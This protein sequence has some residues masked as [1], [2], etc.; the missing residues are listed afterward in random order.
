MATYTAR[1]SHHS[2]S[3]S[4]RHTLRASTET[5]AKREARKLLGDGFQ[6]HRIVLE[7]IA[8]DDCSAAYLPVAQTTIGQA[9]W[10]SL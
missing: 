6:G 8:A 2:I 4:P 10:Q 5:A 1:L 7:E 3:R 9:G